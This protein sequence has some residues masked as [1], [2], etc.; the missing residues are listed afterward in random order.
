MSV[1][2]TSAFPNEGSAKNHLQFLS[3]L[4]SN[5]QYYVTKLKLKTVFLYL[6]PFFRQKKILGNFVYLCHYYDNPFIDVVL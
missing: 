4:F 5:T 1:F 6:L 2:V 3:E